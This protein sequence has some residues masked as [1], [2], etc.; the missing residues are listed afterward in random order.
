[1]PDSGPSSSSISDT[2]AGLKMLLKGKQA[3]E[4][5]KSDLEQYLEDPLD[6][7]DPDAPFD[8]LAWWKVNSP[9][10]PLLAKLTRDILAVPVSTVASEATFSTSGR[11][12]SPIRSSLNDES[13]EALI[14]AQDWL[15]ASVT[16]ERL[17]NLSFLLYNSNLYTD[18]I[19]C[20]L[21][22]RKWWRDW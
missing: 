5:V 8:I 22:C 7:T 21:L 2:R 13:I 4:P 6:T 11:T 14:C 20:F 10:Y 9:K 19:H 16:D 3:A 17:V 18:H 12:L 1:M 15:R